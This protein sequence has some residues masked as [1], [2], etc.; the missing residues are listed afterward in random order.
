MS[1]YRET[2]LTRF[3]NTWLELKPGTQVALLN[4]MMKVIIDKGLFNKEKA[5]KIEGFSS[6]E[7]MLNEYTPSKVSEITGLTEEAVTDAAETFVNAPK[8]LLVMSLSISENNKGLSSALAAA[9][10]LILLGDDPSSL[11]ILAEYCD[12]FG[13]LE[14]GIMPSDG[15]KGALDMLYKPGAF[16]ALYIMGEDHARFEKDNRDIKVT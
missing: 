15:A 3:S 14:A 13:L 10:L 4:G 11:Q 6:L 12:T 16:K 9:N 8:R 1:D 2:K 7:T 5:S